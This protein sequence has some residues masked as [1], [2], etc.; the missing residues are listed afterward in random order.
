[1]ETFWGRVSLLRWFRCPIAPPFLPPPIKIHKPAEAQ[2]RGYGQWTSVLL[3]Q[4]GSSPSKHATFVILRRLQQL[5]HAAYKSGL[6]ITSIEWQNIR[7]QCWRKIPSPKKYVEALSPLLNYRG[8]WVA[9]S[10]LMSY[11]SSWCHRCTRA[12]FQTGLKLFRAL[13]SSNR[14]PYQ[15]FPQSYHATNQVAGDVHHS[16]WWLFLGLYA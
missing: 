13:L 14:I 12:R 6:S 8:K 7:G 15:I 3:N 1:M 2:E 10:Q 5:P 4:A 11:P 16:W 9:A